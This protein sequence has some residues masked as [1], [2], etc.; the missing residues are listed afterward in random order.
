MM[1]SLLRSLMAMP[2]KASMDAPPAP[3]VPGISNQVLSGLSAS[4][5]GSARAG[6][7]AQTGAWLKASRSAG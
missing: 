3:A 2:L 7:T 6:T 5:A 4:Q 1:I